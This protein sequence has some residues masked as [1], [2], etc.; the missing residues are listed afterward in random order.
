MRI[1]FTSAAVSLVATLVVLVLLIFFL[2]SYTY[3]PT[4]ASANL[5]GV[6]LAQQAAWIAANTKVVRGLRYASFVAIDPTMRST[7]LSAASYVFLFGWVSAF[8]G[9]FLQRRRKGA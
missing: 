9:A 3:I 1:F 5:S 4:A 6:P 2:G 7:V 8:A